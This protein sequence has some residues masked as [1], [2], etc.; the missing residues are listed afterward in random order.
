MC[1]ACG[2]AFFANSRKVAAIRR[3]ESPCQCAHCR[4]GKK[5]PRVLAKHRRYWTDKLRSGEIDQEWIDTTV[6]NMRGEP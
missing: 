6:R 5:P 4:R 2:S 3:G 1:E